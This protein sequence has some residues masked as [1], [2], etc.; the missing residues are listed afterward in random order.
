LKSVISYAESY[1]YCGYE[2]KKDKQFGLDLLNKGL[3][4]SEYLDEDLLNDKDIAKA[5]INNTDL[6]RIQ[7][8]SED[9]KNNKEIMLL[10]IKKNGGA[11]KFLSENLKND[12]EIIWEFLI[13]DITHLEWCIGKE[14]KEEIDYHDPKDY[15]EKYFLNEK[16]SKD[17]SSSITKK[18]AKI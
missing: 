3:D 17:L 10:A 8:F 13:Q 7:P 12:K 4:I 11:I 18:R 9:I 6:V 14:L 1:K 16:L 5:T 15:L 2:L